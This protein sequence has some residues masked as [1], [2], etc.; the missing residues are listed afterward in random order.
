MIGKVEISTEA[1]IRLFGSLDEN[2]RLIEDGLGVRLRPFDGVLN[3]EGDE[4][5]VE[6]AIT[7]IDCLLRLMGK[8]YDV[9][10]E[11]VASSIDL[12]LMDKPDEIVA[13]STDVVAVTARGKYVKCRTIGQRAYVSA[14]K[15]STLTFGIGP[16]GTGKTFLAVAMAAAAYKAGEVNRIIL[17]RPAIEAGEK[18]GFLPGDLKEKVDPYLR[19]V[20]DALGEMFGADHAGL[21]ERGTVEIAPLAYMRGRTLSDAFIILDE[22]QNATN[23]QMKM[24]LTRLGENAKMVVNGDLT[25]TD[26]P[27]GESGL[28]KAVEVLKEIK[29]VEVCELT[30]KD[31]VRHELVRQIVLAYARSEKKENG[32]QQD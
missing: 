25:Q 24:F 16:A 29:G 17:T 14:I 32:K 12:V 19:P 26:L 7:L 5:N 10:R 6:R 8:G 31:I 28:R 2:A 21:I 1:L 22:A 9:T 11:K 4:E 18:L 13:L 15:R 20:Y 27:R 3:V 30:E 23:E